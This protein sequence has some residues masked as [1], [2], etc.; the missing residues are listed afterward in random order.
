MHPLID[1]HVHLD[2]LEQP[3]QAVTE[4]RDQQVEGFIVPGVHA[5]D[6]PGLLSLAET[7]PGVW[8]APG[9][10]P[11]AAGAW[12]PSLEAR[13]RAALQ[14]PKVV[15]IG[16][17]GL[18]SRV[19]SPDHQQEAV[20]RSMIRLARD[21]DLPLLL[22]VRGAVGR[23]LE[24]LREEKAE[25]VGGIFHAFSAGLEVARQANELGFALGIGG[26]V[27]YPGARRLPEAVR[28][29]PAEWL[30]L[31][32]DAP[33]MTPHPFRGEAN[34]PALLPLI[35]GEVA[36]LRGWSLA[37]TAKITTANAERILRFT[38]QSR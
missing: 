7:I 10:H 22:H 30:V 25:Q 28:Q 3:L 11:L 37:E 1:T 23:L 15:A 32:S 18:D 38:E 17:V 29:M 2:R 4:A 31:E 14:H 6:W 16:E 19:D 9:L 21:F 35:A 26:I 13:L 36:R 5:A 24:I 34:R 20:F 12:H 33:D 27:T 8:A